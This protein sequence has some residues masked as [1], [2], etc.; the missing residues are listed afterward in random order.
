MIRELR[1]A[2]LDDRDAAWGNHAVVEIIAGVGLFQTLVFG[3]GEPADPAAMRRSYAAL[4]PE[5]YPNIV[6]VARHL[7]PGEDATVEFVV[8]LALDAIEL[9]GAR[10]WVARTKEERG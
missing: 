1:R 8:E 5:T 4:D 10:A 9:R 7:F 6:A 3:L 2:G